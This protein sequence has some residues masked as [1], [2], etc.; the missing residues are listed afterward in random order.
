MQKRILTL[1]LGAMTAI[2]VA[3]TDFSIQPGGLE[4]RLPYIDDA[5]LTLTGSA[6][7]RDLALMRSLPGSVKTVD[8]SGLAIH[9]YTDSKVRYF[10][11]TRFEANEIPAYCFFGAPYTEIKLPSGATTVGE[12]AFAGSKIVSA[13]IPCGV[14]KIA[15]YTFYGCTD[16]TSVTLNGEIA[17]L[18][19]GAFAN[20]S[21]LTTI[22]LSKTAV[23]EIPADCFRGCTMLRQVILPSGVTAVGENAFY[24]SAITELILPE[25]RSLAPYALAGMQKLETVTLAD[26]AEAGEG[27]LMNNPSLTG[28]KGDMAV[29]PSYFTANSPR[30]AT[31][32]TAGVIGDYAFANNDC[33]TLALSQSVRSVGK[34]VF[35]NMTGLT[36]I[37]AAEL[38][39]VPAT[40]EGSFSG[41]EPSTITLHVNDAT[42]DAWRADPEWGLFNIVSNSSTSIP[43]TVNDN[44]IS[45]I[46]GSY[47]IQVA[48]DEEIARICV[49]GA[50]GTLL[51]SAAPGQKTAVVSL[52]GVDDSILIINAE[53]KEH[54]KTVKALRVK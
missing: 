9:T 50:D 34:G 15:D 44:D 4:S 46:V 6:D 11:R 49:Y 1:A 29:Y 41:I 54:R 19:K 16:L 10:N 20:C 47:M 37:D 31:K 40:V 35:H 26:G 32:L 8:L 28:V 48:A 14:K 25:V 43:S 24:G 23:K 2:A 39:A 27:A 13:V 22:D 53:T 21:K 17:S 12:G 3:A 30:V 36:Q 38:T 18:G 7:A 42:A 52:Q 33:N 51:A 45:I 5:T